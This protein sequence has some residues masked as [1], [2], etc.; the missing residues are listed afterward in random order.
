MHEADD[1][2]LLTYTNTWANTQSA[3][4]S[5]VGGLRRRDTPEAAEVYR[6]RIFENQG[7][8]LPVLDILTRSHTIMFQATSQALGFVARPDSIAQILGLEIPAEA[9]PYPV[10]TKTEDGDYAKPR[11]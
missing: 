2:L 10:P 5:K 7:S 6:K 3:R 9:E 11:V 1:M 4:V 8:R